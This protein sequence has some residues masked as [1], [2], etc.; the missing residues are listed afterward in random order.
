LATMTRLGPGA[1]LIPVL[2]PLCAKR[3]LFIAPFGCGGDVASKSF[4]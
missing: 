3:L 2:Q 1:F 4:V